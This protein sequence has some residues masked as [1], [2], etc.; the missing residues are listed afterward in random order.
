MKKKNKRLKICVCQYCKYCHEYDGSYYCDIV[1]DHPIVHKP[2]DTCDSFLMNG[3]AFLR[4][5]YEEMNK[6]KREQ[7]DNVRK[8]YNL[9][10]VPE[11][12]EYLSKLIGLY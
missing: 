6:F 12:T 10:D 4:P 3:S 7:I 2:T 8:L 9:P 1:Y 5:F 11:T